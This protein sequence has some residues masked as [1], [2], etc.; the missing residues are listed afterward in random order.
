MISVVILGSGNVAQHLIRAFLQSTHINLVQA[1]SRN[2][3]ALESL[4]PSDKITD[5]INKITDA[6]VYIVSVSDDAIAQVCESLE[7]SDRLIAHTSGT[8]P[9][10]VIPSRFRRGVFYPLQTFSKTRKID[11][12]TIPFCLE[13]ENPADFEILSN[14]ALAISPNIY[15]MDSNQRKALHVAA[16]FVSNFSNH[17]YAI[18]NKICREN[19]IPF[20]VLKPLIR[21]TA[22]KVMTLTPAEAQTGPAIRHDNGTIESHL[23]FLNGEYRELYEKLTH[24]IQNEQ[25]L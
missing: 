19:D 9:M 4:L 2:R 17:L 25:K 22:E 24:S 5:E 7:F 20:D 11:Y 3:S 23:A 6:D 12:A 16:V 8:K 1:Y 10:D 14:A 13:S 18:G 15:K 21:E